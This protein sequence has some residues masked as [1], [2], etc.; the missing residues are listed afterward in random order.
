VKEK[1]QYNPSPENVIKENEQDASIQKNAVKEV[2][3]TLDE[4]V[5][6]DGMEEE[7]SLLGT[8]IGGGGTSIGDAHGLCINVNREDCNPS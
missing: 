7:T 6:N 2:A 4:E 8:S 1:N 3:T 5:P